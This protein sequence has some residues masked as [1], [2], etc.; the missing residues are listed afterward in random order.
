MWKYAGKLIK[1]DLSKETMNIELF[2]FH[3]EDEQKITADHPLQDMTP[4]LEHLETTNEG[5]T[6]MVEVG[7]L[8]LFL[9]S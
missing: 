7:K 5:T 9:A 3:L 2:M 8:P 6:K 4:V 1:I